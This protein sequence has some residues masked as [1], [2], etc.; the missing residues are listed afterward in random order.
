[1]DS[2]SIKVPD[3]KDLIKID[4]GDKENP[5]EIRRELLEKVKNRA[6]VEMWKYTYWKVFTS[7]KNYKISEPQEL[8]RILKSMNSPDVGLIMIGDSFINKREVKAIDKK[9]GYKEIK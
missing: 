2:M 9:I 1:L 3:K 8:E 6:G 7:H 4:T 5:L